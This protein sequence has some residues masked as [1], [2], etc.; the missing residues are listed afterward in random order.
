[1]ALIIN[2]LFEEISMNSARWQLTSSHPVATPVNWNK[3][4]EVIIRSVKD[5]E[6]VGTL[7]NL[8]CVKY[9]TLPILTILIEVIANNVY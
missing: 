7:S 2:K 4:E 6:T 1:M 9:L 5:E 3:G 8:I